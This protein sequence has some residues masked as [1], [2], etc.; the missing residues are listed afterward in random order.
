MGLS[1][2]AYSPP[3]GFTFDPNAWSS[4]ATDNCHLEDADVTGDGQPSVVRFTTN[5]YDGG[6]GTGVVGIEINSQVTI[7]FRPLFWSTPTQDV[8]PDP[9]TNGLVVGIG[10]VQADKKAASFFGV[11]GGGHLVHADMVYDDLESK[12]K[13][14]RSVV[15]GV[16]VTIGR[17]GIQTDPVGGGGSINVY[18]DNG[19]PVK[20]A[21]SFASAAFTAGSLVGFGAVGAADGSD[22]L[23]AVAFAS[24]FQ[25]SFNPVPTTLAGALGHQ[26]FSQT[27]LATS[28]ALAPASRQVDTTGPATGAIRPYELGAVVWFTGPATGVTAAAVVVEECETSDGPWGYATYAGSNAGGPVTGSAAGIFYFDRSQPY[29][30][31][32]LT[33][34]GGTP[35]LPFAAFILA[36]R[37]TPALMSP[38]PDIQGLETALLKVPFPP[39]V[40]TASANGVSCD[41][42]GGG[43][44]GRAYL[45]VGSLSAGGQIQASI[46]ES[47]DQDAWTPLT[48]PG[49][50]LPAVAAGTQLRSGE[51]VRTKR[52]LRAVLTITGP[53]PQIACAV[54]FIEP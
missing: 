12:L 25:V 52:F 40:R 24:D 19:T 39:A 27:Y 18:D 26:D 2:P 22:T 17:I 32:R 14:T 53:T 37:Y 51:Y 54:V 34:S 13:V 29:A 3:K 23:K 30:R 33:I 28:M 35:N 43:G 7:S 47:D 6:V 21:V 10:V 49:A 41:I 36:P 45:L 5:L 38:P 1:Q 20:F 50:E 48:G 46:E 44:L 11:D 4:L 8:T 9:S 16:P 31:I 15:G 42:Q